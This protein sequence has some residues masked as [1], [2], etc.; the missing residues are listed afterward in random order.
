MIVWVKFHGLFTRIII[1][2]GGH[3]TQC[4]LNK[5]LRNSKYK[6]TRNER[7]ENLCGNFRRSFTTG[8]KGEALIVLYGF[9]KAISRKICNQPIS[10][11]V[12]RI[13]FTKGVSS[14]GLLQGRTPLKGKE[15]IYEKVTLG[16]RFAF[17]L[18][19]FRFL[20]SVEKLFSNTLFA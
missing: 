15:K 19:F 11:W 16:Q 12:F 3:S 6:E 18:S 8:K 4:S 2:T 7:N 13:F 17:Q 5:I 1:P 14:H 10:N 9:L 20:K